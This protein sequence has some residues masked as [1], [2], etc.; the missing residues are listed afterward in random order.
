MQSVRHGEKIVP[1]EKLQALGE[2]RNAKEVL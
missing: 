2:Q 1:T